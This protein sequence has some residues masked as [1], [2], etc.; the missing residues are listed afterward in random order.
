[1]FFPRMRKSGRMRR[2]TRTILV[3][4]VLLSGPT[5]WL[6]S[7]GTT[8]SSTTSSSST[9][10]RDRTAKR[11]EN[12]SKRDREKPADET[13]ESETKSS[14]NSLR[15]ART[16]VPAG[17]KSDPRQVAIKTD[18]AILK[19]RALTA[20]ELN[21]PLAPA[22]Q[23]VMESQVRLET[24]RDYSATFIKREQVQ[25]KIVE[26]SM[27]IKVREAPFSVALKF[28]NPYRGRQ[29]LYVEGKNDGKMLVK[30]EGFKAIVGTLSIDP[31]GPQALAENRHPI[32]EAGISSLIRLALLQLKAETKLEDLHE[33]QVTEDHSVAGLTCHCV[34]VKRTRKAPGVPFHLTRLYLSQETKL[35]VKIENYD[36][37]SG[38]GENPALLE[39]YT[40]QDMKL[41]IG[42]NDQDFR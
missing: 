19:P 41:N 3:A 23:M 37:A 24:I 26:Q 15:S 13:L 4:G 35:P 7:E 34:E 28:N 42:L 1:M 31:A 36:W 38:P 16:S 39:E 18:D 10:S 20:E 12:R 6:L 30:P 8:D 32:T 5:A 40:F 25:G 9:R 22:I 21:H 14:T 2:M 27:E 33:V 17:R 29:V 11:S